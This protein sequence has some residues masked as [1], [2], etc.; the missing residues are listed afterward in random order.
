MSTESDVVAQA[1]SLADA[2]AFLDAAAVQRALTLLHPGTSA[3]WL[4]NT[5]DVLAC[6]DQRCAHAAFSSVK[7]ECGN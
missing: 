6:L 4:D 5:P 2:G 1:L 7:R 3:E